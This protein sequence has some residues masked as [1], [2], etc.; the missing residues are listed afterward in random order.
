MTSGAVLR[1]QVM[2]AKSA[3]VLRHS[4]IGVRSYVKA[5]QRVIV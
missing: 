3:L 5:I 4:L 1:R 2:T